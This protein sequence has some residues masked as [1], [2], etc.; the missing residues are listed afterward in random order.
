MFRRMPPASLL[1]TTVTNS[2]NSK[3]R[4]TAGSAA[5]RS[6][7]RKN[8]SGFVSVIFVNKAGIAIAALDPALILGDLQPHTGMTQSTLA[9]IT[10]NTIGIDNF[11]FRR[12]LAHCVDSPRVFFALDA[13]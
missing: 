1:Q 2:R 3:S 8:G 7:Y 5:I 11:S 13:L 12:V 6:I 9:A 10:G 4:Q